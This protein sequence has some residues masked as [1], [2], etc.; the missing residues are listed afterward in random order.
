[1]N[2]V[3]Y[4]IGRW[5]LKDGGMGR[6]YN[7]LEK[8]NGGDLHRGSPIHAA[9]WMKS[10]DHHSGCWKVTSSIAGCHGSN[11]NRSLSVIPI[12]PF[13]ACASA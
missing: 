3:A 4:G 8:L 10:D 5:C 6:G 13:T 7:G 2:A 11:A 12:Q 1:M 9:G